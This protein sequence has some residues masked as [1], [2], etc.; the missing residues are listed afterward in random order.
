MGTTTGAR[1]AGEIR[2]KIEALAAV[3]RGIDADTLSRAPQGRWSPREIL[4][5]LLGPEEGYRPLLQ[6]FLEADTPTINISVENTFLSEAR[7]AMDVGQL[8][9][10]LKAEYE[11]MA[12]RIEALSEEE[13]GRTARIPQLKDSPL[14]EYPTLGAL[15][16]GLGTYHLQYHTDHLREVL[17]DLAAQKKG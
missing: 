13:F 10:A 15:L 4:S 14:G 7:L 6:A 9:A 11:A 12:V 3:C 2:Q 16:A 5:H 1:T 17:A 8:L